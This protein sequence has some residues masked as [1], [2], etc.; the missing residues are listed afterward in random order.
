VADLEGHT[1][2][3]RFVECVYRSANGQFD[4]GL[5]MTKTPNVYLVVVVDLKHDTV[6]GHRLLDLNREYG[7]TPTAFEDTMRDR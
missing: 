5:V 2:Y 7:I 3:D 6:Y 4:H 1:R